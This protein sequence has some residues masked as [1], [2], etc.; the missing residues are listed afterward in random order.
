MSLTIEHP[1]EYRWDVKRDG[2]LVGMV[3]GNQDIGFLATD[4]EGYIIGDYRSSTMA[5]LAVS[6]DDE[7]CALE[8]IWSRAMFLGQTYDGRL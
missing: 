3:L 5:L 1:R 6:R 2:G 7:I 4:H 8:A